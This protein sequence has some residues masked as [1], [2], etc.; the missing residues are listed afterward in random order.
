VRHRN[1]DGDLG[2]IPMVIDSIINRGT[3]KD[4][5]EMI[6]A[7]KADPHVRADIVA[8]CQAVYESVS[9]LDNEEAEWTWQLY[10]FWQAW[11][12]GD[13]SVLDLVD[14]DHA[15]PDMVWPF[16][17]APV[18]GPVEHPTAMREKIRKPHRPGDRKLKRRD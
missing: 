17:C 2:Y 10:G 5:A 6:A 12:T 3:V 16:P 1:L 9:K 18:I 13:E 14:W 11:A 8:L 15:D 7:A 4:W